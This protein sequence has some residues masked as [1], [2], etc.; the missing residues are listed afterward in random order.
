MVAERSRR[1][2]RH[3]H[4]NAPSVAPRGFDSRTQS[5]CG[6][7]SLGTFGRRFG[8]RPA[9]PP[10]RCTSGL[11]RPTV[12]ERAHDSRRA[13]LKVAKVRFST[14]HTT[15]LQEQ[16]QYLCTLDTTSSLGGHYG[17]EIEVY[18]RHCKQTF[19]HRKLRSHNPDNAM[20]ELHWSL[21]GMWAMGLHSHARVCWNRVSCRSRL[22]LLVSGERIVGRCGNSRALPTAANG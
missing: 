18:Y 21:L 11:V 22:V 4:G 15:Q 1:G 14:Q 12:T 17:W 19:E 8:T 10:T 6:R 20:V 9:T 2:S 3:A 5:G 13:T 16:R 7:R